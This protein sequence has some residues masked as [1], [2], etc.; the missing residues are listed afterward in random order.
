MRTERSLLCTVLLFTSLELCDAIIKR[1]LRAAEN[2]C[3]KANGNLSFSKGLTCAVQ[4]D[5]NEMYDMLMK[6]GGKFKICNTLIHDVIY[7]QNYVLCEKLIRDGID[8]N[9]KNTEGNFPLHIA[10]EID[11]ALI[12]ELLIKHKANVNAENNAK[13]TALHVAVQNGCKDALHIHKKYDNDQSADIIY[14]ENLSY[15]S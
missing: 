13:Q 5:S 1:D 15:F 4:N 10:A 12:V 14:V 7:N 11:N 9:A 2:V 6:Y 8:I 3:R